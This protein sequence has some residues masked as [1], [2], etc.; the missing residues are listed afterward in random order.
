MRQEL[1]DNKKL[2]VQTRYTKQD[3]VIMMKCSIDSIDVEFI[4]SLIDLSDQ[5]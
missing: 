3:F 2:I 4:V 5:T 1:H